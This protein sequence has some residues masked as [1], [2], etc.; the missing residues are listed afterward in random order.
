MTIDYKFDPSLL[1][2]MTDFISSL[3]PEHR[4]LADLFFRDC[5]EF[6]SEEEERE[7]LDPNSHTNQLALLRNTDIGDVE[8][9]KPLSFKEMSTR[10]AANLVVQS[11]HTDMFL[12]P[13]T[14]EALKN[15]LE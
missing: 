4:K 1:D 11:A 12:H 9:Y 7:A 3:N 14:F 5:M 8:P 10:L 15:D 2:Q 13:D 6:E